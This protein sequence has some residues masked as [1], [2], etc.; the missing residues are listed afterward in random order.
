LE[1]NL[2]W[3]VSPTKGKECFDVKRIMPREQ[4]RIEGSPLEFTTRKIVDEA[5]DVAQL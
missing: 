3:S 5:G 1:E 2:K 4:G